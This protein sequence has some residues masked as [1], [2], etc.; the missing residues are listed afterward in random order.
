MS[1]FGKNG[2]SVLN[3]LEPYPSTGWRGSLRAVRADLHHR[4][5]ALAV[6]AD[7]AVHVAGALIAQ[8]AV[9][10]ERGAW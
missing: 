1:T 4:E 10:I 2:T 7:R 3:G 9:R 5:L 8:L 6:D